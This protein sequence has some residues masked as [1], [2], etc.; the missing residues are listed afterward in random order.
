MAAS[1]TLLDRNFE[2]AVVA[3]NW[4]APCGCPRHPT[5]LFDKVLTEA[6]GNLVSPCGSGCLEVGSFTTCLTSKWVSCVQI[7]KH[8]SIPR[9][10]VP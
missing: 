8:V 6:F 9:V 1:V 5:L 4:L 10:L 2:Y 3:Y 7:H